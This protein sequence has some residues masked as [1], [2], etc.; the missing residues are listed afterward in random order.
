MNFMCST[1]VL[2]F[3]NPQEVARFNRIEKLSHID[4]SSGQNALVIPDELAPNL[5]SLLS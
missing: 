3:E 2:L 4:L 5:I 1:D